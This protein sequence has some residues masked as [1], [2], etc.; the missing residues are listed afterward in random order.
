MNNNYNLRFIYL[1]LCVYK[2]I[3]IVYGYITCKYIV[4]IQ[5][6]LTIQGELVIS[7]K[8]EQIF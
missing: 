6:C 2:F 1:C 8:G 5:I 7:I 4:H 3:C